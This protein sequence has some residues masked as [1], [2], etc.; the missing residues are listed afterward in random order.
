MFSLRVAK[1]EYVVLAETRPQRPHAAGQRASQGRRRQPPGPS[2][3]CPRGTEP[4]RARAAAS[5]GADQARDAAATAQSARGS[6]R[7]SGG[8]PTG[9]H[10]RRRSRKT[11]P[12]PRHPG[13]EEARTVAL[14]KRQCAVACGGGALSTALWHFQSLLLFA[15]FKKSLYY[16]FGG[17]ICEKVVVLTTILTI[18][19]KKYTTNIREGI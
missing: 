4:A 17:K 19:L 15:I 18:I 8:K 2:P 5:R 13:G 14:G 16:F 6:P 11:V 10:M 12:R 1:W 7:L 9:E 3:G